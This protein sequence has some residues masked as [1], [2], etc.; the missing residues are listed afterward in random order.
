MAFAVEP[1]LRIELVAAEPLVVDPVAFAFDEQR[2]LYVVECRGWPDKMDGKR[3]KEGKIVLLEDVDGDGRYDKR[4]EFA[5]GLT[6][7][8]GIM[9]WRGGVF[10]TCAPDI[11]YFKDTSGD[12]VADIR[13]VVLTGFDDK[14]YL[15][16]RTSHP[17][18]GLDGK[19]YITSGL[20]SGGKV[21]SPEHPERP[22]V[23]YTT[24]A[25][26]DPDTFEFEAI[27]GR[28][29]YGMCFDSFGRRFIV[30]N[31]EPVLQVMMEPAYLKRN[32]F[33]SFAGTIQEVSD[34]QGKAKVRPI[35]RAVVTADYNPRSMSAPHAGTF[36]SACGL[37]IFGGSGLTPEHS[38][39]AFICEPA[40]NLVQRQALRS[41]GTT[42]RSAP[43]YTDKEFLAS[44]DTWFRPVFLGGGPDG[45]LYVVDMHRREID[46]FAA[47]P[48]ELRGVLDY[49]SGKNAGRIYR[50]VREP[51]R[52]EK[53]G[54]ALADLCRALDSPN[55]WWRERAQRL[56]FERADPAAVPLLTKMAV[57]AKLPEARTLALWILRH[58]RRLSSATI[59]AAL[60]DP[61]AGVREQGVKLAAGALP[62]APELAGPV[63]ALGTDPDAHVRFECALALGS[64]DDP[65]ALPVLA[66]IAVRDGENLWARTA[67][68]S[69]IGTRIPEFLAAINRVRDVNPA[70]YA[71]VMGDLG[72]IFGAGASLD[73]CRRFL[74]QV[75]I[76][77][78][79]SGWGW[80]AALGL[81]DG[82]RE[83]RGAGAKGAANPLA[84]LLAENGEVSAAAAL[85]DFFH[86]A[87]EFAV[88]DQMP[89]S[90]R[91]SA[92]AVLRYADLEDVGSTLEAL[93][94]ARQAPEIQLQAV[95]T[96]GD[97]GD[98]RGARLLV[99]QQNWIHFTPQIRA[100]IIAVLGARDFRRA[101]TAGARPQMAEVLFSA[102]RSG[103][104]KPL[105][106]S[107]SERSRLLE[108]TDAVIRNQ[109]E[110]V[111]Q[112]LVGGDRMEVYR[113]YRD[114]LKVR[115][116][117]ARGQSVFMRAC[118]ACHMY[119]GAGGKVGPDLT[120]IRNQPADA[121]LLH[122]LVPNFE[123][124]PNYQSLT[125]STQDGRMLTGW[126]S[127]ES[128]TSV[129]LRTA[130]GADEA[131]LRKNIASLEATGTSLM[132][133]GLE[134]TMTRAELADVIAYLREGNPALR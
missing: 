19:V 86:R 121:L 22:V 24:D 133:D 1:G 118:S 28:S 44:T 82:L 94:D 115:A 9:C 93:L 69:G 5:D 130:L 8:N 3:T 81:A 92:I 99:Q 125:I 43:R 117:A 75:L 60:R 89:T 54:G 21:Q 98:P 15:A 64:F 112:R 38:G 74:T 42:F 90:Q 116:D 87:R 25:R 80:P 107:S 62:V 41:A 95:R 83:R 32:P 97:F 71:E 46:E 91:V 51:H 39:D 106:V 70:G 53:L 109:A 76:G 30:A 55:A 123:V 63:L 73:A 49:E 108:D 88:N 101:G 45:A 34:T 40:Q 124:V 110:T 72:R 14:K 79:N 119:E 31:R 126:P 77:G 17:I 29:Q 52:A 47:M 113:A 131:I 11:F 56:L 27:G 57:E 36:T 4:T 120:G 66:A 37:V 12:G 105:E 61:H 26:F 10:V 114:I 129:T 65:R 134:Q 128:D 20:K 67:V 18:L 16:A 132:P 6:Y 127:A 104:I 85:E 78:G 2:R 84:A 50:I 33:L 23:T 111:F 35:S 68:L 100:T 48:Q 59:A 96:I 122:I 103:V 102:I 58:Q 13:K 7:P